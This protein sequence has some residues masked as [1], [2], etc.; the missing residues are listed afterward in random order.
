MSSRNTSIPCSRATDLA[1]A[2]RPGRRAAARGDRDADADRPGHRR[3]ARAGGPAALGLPPGPRRGLRAAQVVDLSRPAAVRHVRHRAVQLRAVQ[4]GRLGPAQDARG[5]ARSGRSA[6]RPV[7]LDDTCYF[8]ACESPEQA[9]LVAALLNDPIA[10]DLTPAPDLPR[11]QAADHQG[12]PPADRPGGD[13]RPPD[14]SALLARAEAAAS[15]RSRHRDPG[16]DRGIRSRDPDRSRLLPESPH[17]RS[18][19]G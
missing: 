13:R 10:L 17:D 2:G 5:S 18:P 19:G 7:M 9:A 6:G 15:T 14:R 8:L 12:G 3:L 11:R 16:R 1:P 4:G